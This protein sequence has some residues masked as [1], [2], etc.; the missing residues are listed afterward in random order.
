MTNCLF[1]YQPIETGEYHS[2]CSKKFFGTAQVPLLELDQEKLNKLAEITVNS[3][4][5]LT[6]VQ[7]K[8]SL[9]LSGERGNN[10]LTLVGLWGDYILKP[11]STDFQF[12]PEVEDLT[13]HLAKLFKI[14]TAE[15]ALIRSSTGELAYIT[16][17]FDRK[18][19]KKIHVE[20][21]YELQITVTKNQTVLH[22]K[23]NTLL[24]M[25]SKVNLTPILTELTEMKKQNKSLR[26]QF[27]INF[28]LMQVP[29][30]A[31]LAAYLVVLAVTR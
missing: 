11:Q 17:R 28:L 27:L 8:I 14:E 21:V 31:V 18:K 6:G 15:H 20:K 10:R 22:Q 25:D 2:A 19:G 13:M 24:Q 7:P 30:L 9:S 26:K 4:L 12:M 23:M 3:R 5:A 1:C 29:L 16:K